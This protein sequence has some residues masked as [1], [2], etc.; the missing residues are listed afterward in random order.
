MRKGFLRDYLFAVLRMPKTKGLVIAEQDSL[1]Q[2]L[3]IFRK[4]QKNLTAGVLLREL[5]WAPFPSFQAQSLDPSRCERDQEVT[6]AAATAAARHPFL[7]QHP[8]WE[9]RGFLALWK[10]SFQSR[11]GCIATVWTQTDGDLWLG[12]EGRDT[13]AGVRLGL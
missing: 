10:L 13:G 1:K 12:T 2:L 8:A 4:P 9:T 11:G 3:L 7:V 5:R 6:E